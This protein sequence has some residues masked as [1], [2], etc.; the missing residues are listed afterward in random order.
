MSTRPVP[1]SRS[2]Q[3]PSLRRSQVRDVWMR[4]TRRV[5]RIDPGRGDKRTQTDQPST[6]RVKPI[7]PIRLIYNFNR[8]ADLDK[9][10]LRIL[11]KWI[12]GPLRLMRLASATIV[13]FRSRT[14]VD[15]TDKAIPGIALTKAS[16]HVTWDANV[17]AE[18]SQFARVAPAGRDRKLDFRSVAHARW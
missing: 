6:R 10:D 5:A 12:G 8:S 2:R 14:I 17:P 13:F 4:T 3:R 9:M 16:S 18:A 11:T 7:T 1:S 15:E